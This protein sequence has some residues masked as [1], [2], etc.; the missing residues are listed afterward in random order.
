MSGPDHV[1]SWVCCFVNEHICLVPYIRI[2]VNCSETAT[3]TWSWQNTWAPPKGCLGNCRLKR[4]N[5]GRYRHSQQFWP[6]QMSVWL[7]AAD[8]RRSRSPRASP[9]QTHKQ[10]TRSSCCF[11]FDCVYSSS[12]RT[13][14]QV[15]LLADETGQRTDHR[16]PFPEPA[17]TVCLDDFNV[18]V[19]V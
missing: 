9:L 15:G 10:S 18:K 7:S 6:V 16:V 3:S 8:I 4:T 19:N 11:P 2:I 1:W 14:L 17:E 12:S 13:F 5:T